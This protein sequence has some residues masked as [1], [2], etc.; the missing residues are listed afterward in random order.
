VEH[1]K[2]KNK[3]KIDC[4]VADAPSFKLSYQ[5]NP[6]APLEPS[7]QAISSVNIELSFGEDSVACD[8][9]FKSINH[10]V[11]N[12]ATVGIELLKREY[13]Q[14]GKPPLEVTFM[15]FAGQEEYD[16]DDSFDDDDD[17]DS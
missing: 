11:G 4:D 7:I 14:H 8:M 2:N 12:T 17:D 16:D 10:W 15:D 13:E 1:I 3:V 5:S 6:I 9:W